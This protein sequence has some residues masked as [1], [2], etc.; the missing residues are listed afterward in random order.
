MNTREKIAFFTFFLA[1][2]FALNPITDVK[3]Q[4]TI[5]VEPLP[6]RFDVPFTVTVQGVD[7]NQEHKVY[8][9]T[10]T[11]S[12]KL[13]TIISSA[14]GSFTLSDCIIPLQ[15]NMPHEKFAIIIKNSLTG[16][17]IKKSFLIVLQK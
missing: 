6:L 10:T 3:A 11:K 5:L 15:S 1:F 2:L 7:P 16:N 13:G 17:K 14:E 4:D 8:Y 9:I 12:N